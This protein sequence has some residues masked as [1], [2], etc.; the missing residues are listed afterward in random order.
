MTSTDDGFGANELFSGEKVEDVATPP[1]AA[2]PMAAIG[3]LSSTDNE[4]EMV[5]GEGVGAVK[6]KKRRGK[7]GVRKGKKQ[8]E[9]FAGFPLAPGLGPEFA[10]QPRRRLPKAPSLEIMRG[11]HDLSEYC[12]QDE[13]GSQTGS[14]ATPKIAPDGAGRTIDNGQEDLLPAPGHTRS[15]VVDDGGGN[16]YASV[17]DKRGVSAQRHNQ[18]DGADR[19]EGYD[20][21]DCDEDDTLGDNEAEEVYTAL[22]PAS[23]DVQEHRQFAASRQQ[24]RDLSD[25]GH[26]ATADANRPFGDKREFHHGGYY[27]HPQCSPQGSDNDARKSNI[28]SVIPGVQA[29]VVA[30]E[31]RGSGEGEGTTLCHSNRRLPTPGSTSSGRSLSKRRRR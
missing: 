27:A 19:N 3:T 8:M 2:G 18:E 1:A 28:S 26:L 6:K 22:D 25:W 7:R 16:G 15:A 9:G 31:E 29:V 5:S 23:V 30:G 13:S 11:E 20:E 10:G 12:L 21:D 24:S 17:A 14:D 4:S